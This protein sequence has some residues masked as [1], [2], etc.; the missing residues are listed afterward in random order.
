M[1][2]KLEAWLGIYLVIQSE[3]FTKSAKHTFA[4]LDDD[5]GILC[6]AWIAMKFD[7][8]SERPS[9]Y[10]RARAQCNG[11]RARNRMLK[12]SSCVFRNGGWFTPFLLRSFGLLRMASPVHRLVASECG[13]IVEHEHEQEHRDAEHEHDKKP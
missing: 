12:E 1:Q 11:A 4:V 7:G 5:I 9:G 10:S 8:V 3:R 2:P 6:G 13:G